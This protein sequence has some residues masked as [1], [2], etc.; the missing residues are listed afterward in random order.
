MA[1]SAMSVAGG[2][3]VRISSQFTNNS[4]RSWAKQIHYMN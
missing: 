2:M 4:R 3:T 1:G